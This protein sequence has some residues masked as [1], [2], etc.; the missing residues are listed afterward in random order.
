MG[1]T[2]S[3][4]GLPAAIAEAVGKRKYLDFQRLSATIN[5]FVF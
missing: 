5:V 4:R 1:K 3:M 2:P